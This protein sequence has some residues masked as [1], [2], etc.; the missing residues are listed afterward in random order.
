[1]TVVAGLPEK[2]AVMILGE[3]AST[4]HRDLAVRGFSRNPTP[5]TAAP[6]AFRVADEVISC[7]PSARFWKRT[8][9]SS[10]TCLCSC[11]AIIDMLYRDASA[12]SSPSF[13][14]DVE[15][16]VRTLKVATFTSLLGFISVD[17]VFHCLS[18]EALLERF[19]VAASFC[20]EFAPVEYL[21]SG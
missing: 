1:M 16:K 15:F 18:A 19:K 21:K 7:H 9:M 20:V 13:D 17:L 8:S 2:L 12:T 10:W 14:V 3:I 4:L 11:N 6:E 5:P